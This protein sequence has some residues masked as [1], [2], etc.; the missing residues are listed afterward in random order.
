LILISYPLISLCTLGLV[1]GVGFFFA[2]LISYY[3][4]CNIDVS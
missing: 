2:I 4:I 3:F 1:S